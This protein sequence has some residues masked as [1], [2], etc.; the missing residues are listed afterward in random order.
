[1]IAHKGSIHLV[2]IKAGVSRAY[3]LGQGRRIKMQTRDVLPMQLDGEPW[4][5]VRPS[6]PALTAATTGCSPFLFF[7]PCVPH[8]Q[9]PALIQIEHR[10]QVSMIVPKN[11]KNK[12]A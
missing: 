7:R 3:Q 10:N 1:M 2:Q 12:S 11:R 6:S 4:L 8:T 5:Q 9:G